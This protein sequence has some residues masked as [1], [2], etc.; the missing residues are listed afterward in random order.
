[1]SS[2]AKTRTEIQDSFFSSYPPELKGVLKLLSSTAKTRTLLR[3]IQSTHPGKLA[4]KFDSNLSHL[5]A[6]EVLSRCILLNDVRIKSFPEERS[7]AEIVISL[8]FELTNA[9]G[10]TAIRSLVK[11]VAKWTKDEFV[12][13][14]EAIEHANALKASR[15]VEA[16]IRDKKLPNRNP[17]RAISPQFSEHYLYQQLTGHSQA[18]AHQY[19]L[20]RP[21]QK[22]SYQGTWKHPIQEDER[23][24]LKDYFSL[25]AGVR[26]LDASIQERSQIQMKEFLS[27]LKSGQDAKEDLSSRLLTHLTDLGEN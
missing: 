13:K 23:G 17:F 19:D 10:Q 9:L 7:Q 1:M 21:G 14:W 24:L 16:L 25:R 11:H 26:S 27:K 4:V 18:I 5:A 8:V 20:L 2:V 22:T 12:E 6:Y 3:D 15:Y